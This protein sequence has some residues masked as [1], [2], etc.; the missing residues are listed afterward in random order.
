MINPG[1]KKIV[2]GYP[3]TSS[4]PFPTAKLNTAKKRKKVITGDKTVC[5]QTLKNLKTSLI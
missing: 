5:I 2:K 4:L 3:S 1:I